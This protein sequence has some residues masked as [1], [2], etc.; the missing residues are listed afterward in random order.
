MAVT[1]Q[2]IADACGVS[3]GTVDRALR[4]REGIRP[5]VAERVR[6]QARQMGYIPK[7]TARIDS[8]ETVRIGVVLHSGTT[9]FVRLLA[10]L[11]NNFPQETLLPV[12]PIVRIMDDTNV[13][14]QLALIEELVENEQIDGLAIMPLASTQIR[15][16]VNHLIESCGLPVVTL[17][18]DL[19]D[20][21]RM[22]YVGPDDLASGRTA[23]GLL[24]MTLAQKGC[25]LPILGQHSGHFADTQRWNGFLDEM[26]TSFP[27]IELL[28]PE[29]CFLDRGLAERITIRAM[30]NHPQLNGIYISSSGREGVC[31][32]VTSRNAQ[33][34]I[35][36]VAHDLT[37]SNIRMIR[38][39]VFDFVIGQDFHTQAN[40]PLRL[41]YQYITA[42]QN[43]AQREFTTDIAIKFRCN[44]LDSDG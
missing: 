34:K 30:Q 9:G 8:A 31:R 3:R 22:A 14:H 36:I 40:L 38:E 33:G 41:L 16:A 2:Q 37:P 15:D 39:G 13:L 10:Q 1:M 4:N 44:L 12:I 19:A 6:A 27:N 35:H 24:G 7:H 20:C 5:E 28:P 42:R 11:I 25:I 18:T 23:A 21:A 32:A 29:Y 26:Q 17:N 43:P